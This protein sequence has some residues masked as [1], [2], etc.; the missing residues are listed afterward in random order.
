[1]HNLHN[2]KY[3]VVHDKKKYE[4]VLNQFNPKRFFFYIFINLNKNQEY[5]FKRDQWREKKNNENKRIKD[6][7]NLS[8][9]RIQIF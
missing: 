5:K 8:L 4:K 3:H 6:A 9:F 7:N 2:N 1:M